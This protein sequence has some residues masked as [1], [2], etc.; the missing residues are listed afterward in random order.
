MSGRSVSLRDP[1]TVVP[2]PTG[3]AETL[4]TSPR[5]TIMLGVIRAY[6]K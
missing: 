2:S 6:R 3:E 1:L 4:I 5:Y